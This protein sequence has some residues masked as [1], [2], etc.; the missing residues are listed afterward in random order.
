MPTRVARWSLF[1]I[2]VLSSSFYKFSVEFPVASFSSASETQSI[3]AI[4]QELLVTHSGPKAL[5][6]NAQASRADSSAEEKTSDRPQ[7]AET[8]KLFNCS[9]EDLSACQPNN[10]VVPGELVNL[11]PSGSIVV[12][13]TGTIQFIATLINPHHKAWK[14]IGELLVKKAD[15]SVLILLA[16]REIRLAR[17]QTLTLPVGLPADPSTFSP[18]LNEFVAILRDLQGNLI[19]QASVTFILTLDIKK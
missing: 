6:S 3:A 10:L 14:V 2:L 19:D 5:E 11:Q 9:L 13:L 17:G 7:N 1:L 4:K 18:G 16:P 8:E 12:P 15:G